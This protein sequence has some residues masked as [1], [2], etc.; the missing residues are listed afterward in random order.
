M[1]NTIVRYVADK[2]LHIVM[3]YI[4]QAHDISH[5]LAQLDLETTSSHSIQQGM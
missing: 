4:K 5:I 1:L 2:H 3:G